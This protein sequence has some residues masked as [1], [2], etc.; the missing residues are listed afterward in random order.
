MILILWIT[1]CFYVKWEK[2]GREL[3]LDIA[4]N[5][6]TNKLRRYYKNINL[7]NKTKEGNTFLHLMIKFEIFHKI[8]GKCQ[9]DKIHYRAIFYDF[10]SVKAGRSVLREM[11]FELNYGKYMIIKNNDGKTIRDLILEYKYIGYNDRE[12]MKK[13]LLSFFKIK[14]KD[15]IDYEAC[16]SVYCRKKNSSCIIS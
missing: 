13:D 12:R 2:D 11:C 4:I 8:G 14:N 10:D 7:E 1:T 9:Y 5:S 16:K 3:N 15:S 6:M